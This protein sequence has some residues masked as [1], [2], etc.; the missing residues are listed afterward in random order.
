MKKL[1]LL[2]LVGS[3]LLL[4]V[5]GCLQGEN[6]E[7]TTPQNITEGTTSVPEETTTPDDVTLTP[8]EDD[9]VSFE[10]VFGAKN[11]SFTAQP[12]LRDASITSGQ[13][14]LEID[15][16]GAIRVD[17]VLYGSTTILTDPTI[18]YPQKIHLSTDKSSDEVYEILAEIQNASTCYMLESEADDETVK[19]LAVYNISGT[20]YLLS[21]HANGVVAEIHHVN[22]S[23]ATISVFIEYESP[24]LY[25][26]SAKIPTKWNVEDGDIPISLSFGT[27]EAESINTDMISNVLFTFIHKRV[28]YEFKRIDIAEILKSDYITKAIQDKEQKVI[29][30]Y[31]YAHTEIVY[32]PLSVLSDD[33][34]VIS[35]LMREHGDNGMEGEGAGIGFRYTYDGESIYISE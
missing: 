2:I 16:I 9:T 1:I 30:A 7:Q 17:N 18:V 27:L 21:F 15:V 20:H 19:M 28:S 25:A 5:T 13:T 22:V 11:V 23:E 24:W 33:S 29:I 4:T 32:L 8:P 12:F 26:I 3:L 14:G 35:I 10:A 34:G 6:N 31:D